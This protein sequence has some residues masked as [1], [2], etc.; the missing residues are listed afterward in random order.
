VSLDLLGFIAPAL[1][2]VIDLRAE[3]TSKD[4]ARNERS[5]EPKAKAHHCAERNRAR[6]VINQIVKKV[7]KLTRQ[8]RL[9][10]EPF[11]F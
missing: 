9:P 10:F 8:S 4:Y 2:F 5:C 6:D 3:E 1:F 11:N 7:A